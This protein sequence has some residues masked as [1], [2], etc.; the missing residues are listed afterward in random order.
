MPTLVNGLSL[1]IHR[2]GAGSPLLFLHGWGTSGESFAGLSRA[3]Q[4]SY[5][6]LGPDLPGFGRSAPPPVPWCSEEYAAHLGQWLREEGIRPAA[7]FGHS[8][9]GKVALRLAQAGLTDRL[10]LFGSA[11]IPPRRP[12]AY[13]AKVY[14]F[15]ALKLLARI[16]GFRP[17]FGDVAERM[18]RRTGSADYRAAVG[19]MR[20]SLVR[21]VNEDIRP[22]LPR[23]ACPTLLVWGRQ[24]TATPVGDAEI[25]KARLPDAGLVVVERA[26]H[27][28]FVD[29]PTQVLAVVQAFL[30]GASAQAAAS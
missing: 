19:V 30:Q 11:G 3:L 24:D 1:H 26:G 23:V 27:Y 28:V 22:V 10:V 2:S 18:R 25:M 15:K 7:I 13:Y 17:L 20:D 29:Q 5:D 9:G 21:S 4:G 16:P 6:C 8:F 14:T 12:P